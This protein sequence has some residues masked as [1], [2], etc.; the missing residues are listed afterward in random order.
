MR[1]MF[2]DDAFSGYDIIKDRLKM[3]LKRRHFSGPMFPFL[4]DM[5]Y[6]V[7]SNRKPKQTIRSHHQQSNTAKRSNDKLKTHFTLILEFVF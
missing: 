2:R 7:K 4:C 5:A 3:L 1:K 6:A